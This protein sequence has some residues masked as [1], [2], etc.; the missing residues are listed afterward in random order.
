MCLPS[1]VPGPQRAQ[2]LARRSP[3][4]VYWGKPVAQLSPGGADLNILTTSAR[5]EIALPQAP[6]KESLRESPRKCDCD[7]SVS[8]QTVG[9]KTTKRVHGPDTL[10]S[11]LRLQLQHLKQSP[12]FSLGVTFS[13]VNLIR[14]SLFSPSRMG[15][16][17][18]NLRIDPQRLCKFYSKW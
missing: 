8:I 5:T 18:W 7:H 2:S 17:T 4:E 16:Q 3:W 15:R 13:E 9:T 6:A 1:R 12:W 10:R 14:L 11:D